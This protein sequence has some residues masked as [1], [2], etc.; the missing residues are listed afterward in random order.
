MSNIVQPGAPILF[1]KVGTHAREPL[2]QIIARKTKEI[3]RNGYA[4]W[5]YGGS[6]CHPRSMV[7]PFARQYEQRGTQIYLCMQPMT[8]KHW[9]EPVRG[10]VSSIDGKSWS[11]IPRTINCNGSKYA[12][13]IKDLKP[14]EF[15]LDLAKTRVAMGNSE[16]RAGDVYINGRVDKACLE[17]TD[18]SVGGGERVIGIGLVAQLT[19]PYAVYI[20][21]EESD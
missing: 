14:A 3:E 17:V 21:T 7:Q 16:G 5:G 8:S 12:L 6:T 13:V 19:D 15:Q 2:E 9:A 11:K 1:M 10:S 20:K 18:R 4:L